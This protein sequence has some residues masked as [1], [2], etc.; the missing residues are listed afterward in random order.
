MEVNLAALWRKKFTLAVCLF[1]GIAVGVGYLMVVPPTFQAQ[2]RVLVEPQ[3]VRPAADL[4]GRVDPEFLPTQAETIRSPVTISRALHSV[5]IEP[6]PGTDLETFDPVRH[7]LKHLTVTP[8]LKA[9]VVTIG[10]RST[11]A[12]ES[13][14]VISSIVE[15]YQNHVAELDAGNSESN[16]HVIASREQALREDLK[17]AQKQYDELCRSSP[18]LGQGREAAA[19]AVIQLNQLGSQLAETRQRRAELEGRLA[20]LM[21]PTAPRSLE[22]Y[23]TV[24]LE[25]VSEG[26]EERVVA[27]R[28]ELR[29]PAPNAI[30][31][32]LSVADPVD[33][34]AIQD[35][36]ERLRFAES[37]LAQL[38][39]IYGPRHP[40]MVDARAAVA[41]LEALQQ[42]RL[43]D[44]AQ[45]WRRHLTMTEA[46]EEEL[47]KSYEAEQR[48]VKEAEAYLVQE[49][50]LKSNL[51]RAEQLHAA[52]MAQLVQLQSA[53]DAVAEGRTSIQ[54]RLLDGPAV[55]E[56]MTWPKPKLLLPFSAC[57]GLASGIFLVLVRDEQTRGGY[58][59]QSS[60]GPHRMPTDR[61]ELNGNDHGKVR[62]LQKTGAAR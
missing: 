48:R 3:N 27:R 2:A 14:E 6:P 12:D 47:R 50:F 9:N 32:I 49:Q 24:Q 38:D 43:K 37:R 35:I 55:L 62:P 34:R 40:E 29:E 61:H 36:G 45:A 31:E 11:D 28:P 23:A 51:E 21:E 44:I 42:Q 58:S 33:A 17:T 19:Q 5:T 52:T 59:S 15:S 1:V 46:A 57:L 20:S 22:R 13:L 53:E 56:E 25:M 8:I 60:S 7:V 54:V 4:M 26:D 41:E 30:E 10:Y 39:E 16:A 18:L